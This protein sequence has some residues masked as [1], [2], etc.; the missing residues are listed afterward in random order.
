[1]QK[2]NS[3]KSHKL[4]EKKNRLNHKETKQIGLIVTKMANQRYRLKIIQNSQSGVECG[5][6]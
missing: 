6:R 2:F 3:S 4:M 5:I 1:M